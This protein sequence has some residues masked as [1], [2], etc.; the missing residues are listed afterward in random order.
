MS[1]AIDTEFEEERATLE[2]RGSEGAA[3]ALR[4]SFWTLLAGWAT[5]LVAFVGAA[6]GSEDLIEIGARIGGSLVL[7]ALALAALGAIRALPGAAKDARVRVA[8]GV[9]ELAAKGGA[10]RLVPS[11]HVVT[12]V[13]ERDGAVQIS[14][15]EGEV[16]RVGV[17]S[18]ARA[19]GLLVALGHAASARRAVLRWSAWWQR[20]LAFLAGAG[21]VL[22]VSALAAIALPGALAGAALWTALW[23]PW[24]AGVLAQRWIGG[25][26]VEIGADAVRARAFPWGERSARIADITDVREGAL[27]IELVTGD[28]RALSIPGDAPAPLRAAMLRRVAAA[29]AALA[30]RRA[31]PALVALLARGA[32]AFEEWRGSLARV[33]EAGATLR[34]AAIGSDR[35]AAVLADAGAPADQRVGA[36]LALLAIDRAE[37]APRVRVAAETSAS[38]A[39]RVALEAAAAGELDE[40]LLEAAVRDEAARRAS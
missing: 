2:A 12:A 11:D 22:V 6:E 31:D 20:G 17:G 34:E 26:E 24:L 18:V 40:P 30:D 3:R 37:A 29:R 1:D 27:A 38:P 16:M 32:R 5:G 13:H 4:A 14:L 9:L 28:G 15:R 10:T 25:R 35:I 19:E 36:A 21:A 23:A 7:I 8:R 33:R 39:L